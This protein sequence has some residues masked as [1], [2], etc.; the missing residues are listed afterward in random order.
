M[1]L[2]GQ[3]SSPEH[4]HPPSLC[5]RPLSAKRAESFC[6]FCLQA[7]AP[8]SLPSSKSFKDQVLSFGSYN[9]QSLSRDASWTNGNQ[10]SWALSPCPPLDP[11]LSWGITWTGHVDCTLQ[12]SNT[13]VPSEITKWGW[14]CWGILRRLTKM[15]LEKNSLLSAYRETRRKKLRGKNALQ[16]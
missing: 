10:P 2:K 15:C 8:F 3:I 5:H 11:S 9:A 13:S 16:W 6:L 14:W 1:R 7:T 12:S 4:P